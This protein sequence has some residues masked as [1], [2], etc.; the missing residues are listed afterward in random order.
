MLKCYFNITFSLCDVTIVKNGYSYNCDRKVASSFIHIWALVWQSL[1]ESFEILSQKRGTPISQY[2]K[3]FSC[4]MTTMWTITWTFGIR[5]CHVLYTFG[6]LDYYGRDEVQ[7]SPGQTFKEKV[8]WIFISFYAVLLLVNMR[9]K[10]SISI[11]HKV[12]SSFVH[13][14]VAGLLWDTLNTSDTRAIFLRESD[15]NFHQ[16]LRGLSLVNMRLKL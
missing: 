1:R 5:C 14:W 6:S 10:L 3:Y 12:L 4:Y 13:I 2:I 7:L 11:L 9:H 8:I 16:L 15:R